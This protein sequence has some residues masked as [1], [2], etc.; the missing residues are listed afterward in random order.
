MSVI[1]N[2]SI[3]I[4][5]S[6][7]C[8]LLKETDQLPLALRSISIPCKPRLPR[9][10]GRTIGRPAA[11]CY[12]VCMHHA[13]SLHLLLLRESGEDCLLGCQAYLN[14]HFFHLNYEPPT[15]SICLESRDGHEVD[16]NPFC[17]FP[18]CS[19]PVSAHEA[20]DFAHPQQPRRRKH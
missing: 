13:A 12:Y 3:D 5:W 17:I 14:T 8:S 6:P 9:T 11:C 18:N 19:K 15:S 10:L 20:L 2:R 1:V 7:H 4:A 16:F